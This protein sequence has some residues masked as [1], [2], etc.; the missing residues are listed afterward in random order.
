M[1]RVTVLLG[2]LSAEREVSLASGTNCV[3]ALKEAGYTVSTVDAGKDLVDVITELRAQKPDV[4]FNALHG[5]YGEDGNIQGVLNLLKIPY[6]HSGLMASSLAMDKNM[7]KR[8][9][10]SAGLRVP[11]GK[12]L[13][14]A[15]VLKGDPLPRPYVVKPFNEGS[16]VGVSIIRPG[17]NA[18]PFDGIDWPFGDLVLAERFIPGRELTCGVMGDKPMAVTELR[19]HSGFYDYANKYTGGRTDHLIPA[20]LPADVYAE[21]QRMAVAAHQVLGCRGVSRSDFRYDDTGKGGKDEIYLL[22]TNTQP[23]MTELSLVPEM[24]RHAEISYPQLVSWMVEH[25]RCDA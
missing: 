12:L 8:L 13:T 19:P 18:K 2:G 10:V 17:D 5:R 11:D 20:P 3:E 23:G 15:E 25:A 14:R 22:E 7:A 4:V 1:K 9:F 24:A 16:S 21:V 6:T